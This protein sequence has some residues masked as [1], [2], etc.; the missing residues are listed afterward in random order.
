MKRTWLVVLAAG[1]VAGV[2]VFTFT[3]SGTRTRVAGAVGMAPAP[4]PVAAVKQKPVCSQMVVPAGD[5]IPQHLA[6]LPP[7]PGA[8]GM[9]TIEGIDADKDGVRDDVQRYIA[10]TWGS[11]DK[12]V[13][14]LTMAAK[15]ELLQVK[16]GD[17]LGKEETRKLAPDIIR[18]ARCLGRL[19]TPELMNDRAFDLVRIKV[20]NTPERLIRAGDFNYMLAHEVYL[21]EEATTAELCGFD[22]SAFTN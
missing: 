17:S 1:I 19:E 7:D 2:L 13:R 4:A 10:E 5:C 11:S 15:L 3:D 12:A 21:F 14:L 18:Q 22:P 8:A 9:Q 20:T 16:Y 6:A